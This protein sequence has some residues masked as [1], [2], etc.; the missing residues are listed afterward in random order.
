M[1]I[2]AICFCKPDGMMEYS[3]ATLLADILHLATIRIRVR[4]CVELC[5]RRNNRGL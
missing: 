5:L 2:V 4:V 3:S 1:L